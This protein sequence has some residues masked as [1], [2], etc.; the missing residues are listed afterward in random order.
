MLPAGARDP[1]WAL[2][3][4]LSRPPIGPLIQSPT[5]GLPRRWSRDLEWA[6]GGVSAPDG[7]SG[8][9]QDRDRPIN[10]GSGPAL[11]VSERGEWGGNI[12]DLVGLWSISKKK[13]KKKKRKKEKKEER[14]TE[15]QKQK[16]KRKKKNNVTQ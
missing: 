10:G 12:V 13:K 11:D 3:E 1:W 5:C 6:G 7:R 2:F 16:N 8:Q 15:K 14:K 9:Q 4:R